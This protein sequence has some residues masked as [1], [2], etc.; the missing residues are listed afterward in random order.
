M[1]LLIV[2]DQFESGGAGRVTA[3]MCCELAR[4]G[5]DIELVADNI[6]FPIRY[7][8]PVG[9]KVHSV[10]FISKKLVL[11]QGWSLSLKQLK[12]YVVM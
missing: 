10:E 12:K 1:R 2:N 8:L 3:T 4:R 5:Y 7:T 9:V 11:Y 6:N